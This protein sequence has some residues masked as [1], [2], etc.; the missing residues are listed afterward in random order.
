MNSAARDAN[1]TKINSF[2]FEWP[3]CELQAD[4]D[5][6]TF[7]EH[8]LARFG[9]HRRRERGPFCKNGSS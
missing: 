5:F 9:G 3:L 2:D 7:A 8:R 6:D 1:V 4:T